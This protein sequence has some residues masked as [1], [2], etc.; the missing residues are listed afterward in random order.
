MV[1][2]Y[3]TNPNDLLSTVYV[4]REL[5]VSESAVRK[6]AEDGRLPCIRT[7]RGLRLF[8]AADVSRLAEERRPSR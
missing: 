5:G 4:A 2:N 6:M 3:P 1:T 7:Q 8:K